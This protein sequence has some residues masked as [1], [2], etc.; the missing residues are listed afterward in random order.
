MTD[1]QNKSVDLDKEHTNHRTSRIYIR[2][3]SEEKT[4]IE[5]NAGNINTSTFLRDLGLR[6]KIKKLYIDLSPEQKSCDRN[7]KGMGNNINQLVTEIH[8]ANKKGVI[9]ADLYIQLLTS[10]QSVD[11]SM[12]EIVNAVS[13]THLTLPTICSV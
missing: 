10:L 7:L 4:K 8:T 13:Y 12:L 2:V 6:K 9:D 1:Q 11:D 5:A 3:T